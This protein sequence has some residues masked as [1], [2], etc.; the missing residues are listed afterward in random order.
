MSHHPGPE[1][2]V[3]AVVLAGMG[4]HMSL[5][6]V[7]RLK[8]PERGK[9]ALPGGFVQRFETPRAAAVREL[10]EETGL[11]LPIHAAIPL[12][13]RGKQGR[14]PRGWVVTRPFLFHLPAP[15]PVQGSDEAKRPRWC[16]LSE[17]EML[18][19]DH[20]AILCEALGRFW[21]EMPMF[22]RRLAGT[23]VFGRGT[24]GSD[25]TFFGGSFNPWHEGHEA[26]L[27]LS[28]RHDG[29]VVVPDANPFKETAVASCAWRLVHDLMKSADRFGA[30]VF[31]GFCGR[32][33]AN[34]TIGWLPFVAAK[35][36]GLLIGD[37]S[38]VDFPRWLEAA[39][40]A[41]QLHHLYV[42]P[43]QSGEDEIER[44]RTWFARH[45]PRTEIRFL[46]NHPHRGVSSTALRN[47]DNG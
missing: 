34:P 38:F 26:C 36:K 31:P 25:L 20:G 47:G 27:R 21:P 8:E 35:R 33:H 44:A 2:A 32:E 3:D 12:S 7:E 16:S 5:L 24:I 4:E 22:D 37:D 42:V 14:D 19:F 15:A 17:L 10:R 40:L 11:D 30:V 29:L 23:P 6:V 45:S 41:R 13:M 9:P 39:D 43:R 1:L 28:P 18:A 46:E